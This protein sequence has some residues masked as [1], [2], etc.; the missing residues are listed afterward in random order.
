MRFLSDCKNAM[1]MLNIDDFKRHGG[2]TILCIFD[3]AGGAE[4]GVAAERDTLDGAALFTAK[5]S[6]AFFRVTAR[7]HSVDIFDDRST[8]MKG[9]DHFF[10]MIQKDLLQNISAHGSIMRKRRQKNNYPSRLRGRGVEVS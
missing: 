6:E 3:T 2:D 8:G 5:D 4:S 7:K 10:I 1:T 9:I